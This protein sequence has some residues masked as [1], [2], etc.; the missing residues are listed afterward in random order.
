MISDPYKIQHLVPAEE[1]QLRIV[2]KVNWHLTLKD[3]T[4]LSNEHPVP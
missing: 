3:D 1:A 4:Q 2:E